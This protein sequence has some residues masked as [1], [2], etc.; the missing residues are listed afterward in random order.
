MM[1]TIAE[2]TA[3]WSDAQQGDGRA[4]AALFDLHRDR[5]YRHALRL[6]PSASDAEDVVAAA[7]FELWRRRDRVR[8]VDGSVLPWL[9]V[10]VTNLARNTSRG[11][12]RHRAALERLPRSV[13]LADPAEAAEERIERER[14][15][16]VLRGL[17]PADAALLVLTGV[18]DYG[19]AEAAQ[20]L[21]ITPG[22]ARVR[23]HRARK[24][25]Q[26]RLDQEGAER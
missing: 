2:E 22:A 19:P 3:L 13:D 16:G 17:S 4:F 10:T 26:E 7:F 21:G 5:A 11:L 15:L 8:V 24:R 6:V 9:L 1:A 18:E 12:R 14:L 25:M 23:L 20:A